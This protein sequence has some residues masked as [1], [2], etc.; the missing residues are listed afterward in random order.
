MTAGAVSV[1]ATYP[2][3]LTRA[4]LAVLRTKTGPGQVNNGF[5]SVIYNNYQ[6]RGVVGLFRGI[7]P[8]LMGI[9]PYS[10]LAFAFNEQAKRKVYIILLLI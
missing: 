6:S 7:T 10:G 5:A 9:L 4:Q 2:L 1:C 3:D 8:T